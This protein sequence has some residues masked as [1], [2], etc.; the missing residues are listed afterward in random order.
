M[1]EWRIYIKNVNTPLLF[2]ENLF[3]MLFY[4]MC[5]TLVFLSD[6]KGERFMNL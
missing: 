3:D 1:K 5:N 6:Y 2:M 4:K